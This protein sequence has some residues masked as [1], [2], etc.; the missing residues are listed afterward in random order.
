[1]ASPPCVLVVGGANLDVVARADVLRPDASTPGFVRFG[2]GGSAR[3]VAEALSRLGARVHLLCAGGHGALW[4]LVLGPTRAAGVVVHPVPV[5]PWPDTYVAVGT[6]HQRTW[7]VSDVR[8]CEALQPAHL[9]QVAR[10]GRWDAVVADSN[11]TSALLAAVAELPA[12]RCLLTVSPAKATRLRPRLEGTWLVSCAGP[13]A[14]VLSGVPAADPDGAREAARALR[15]AGCEHVVVTLGPAGLVWCGEEEVFVPA[16]PV[17]PQDPTGAGDAVA[18]CAVRAL[19]AGYP[20]REAAVLCAW[21][22]ALTVQVEGSVH[23]NLS[24][25]VLCEL[26]GL[27]RRP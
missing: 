13:E 12:R 5:R 4:E 26:A 1:M 10:G 16:R 27:A 20:D 15:R 2:P 21:A 3:N 19:L 11:L 9:L 22:G 23:P 14:E 24:L 18:A 25:E 8:A 17:V 6:G 7:A